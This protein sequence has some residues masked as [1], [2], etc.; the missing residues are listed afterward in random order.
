[1]R[2]VCGFQELWGSYFFNNLR[3]R[4]VYSLLADRNCVGW[5]WGRKLCELCVSNTIRNV[6][7]LWF[8][9]C[10]RRSR[11]FPASCRRSKVQLSMWVTCV[12]PSCRLPVSLKSKQDNIHKTGTHIHTEASRP[13]RPKPQALLLVSIVMSISLLSSGLK[14]WPYFVMWLVYWAWSALV[15][16]STIQ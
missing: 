8:A 16:P 2:S 5:T 14:G 4:S 7:P 11:S 9:C 13:L 10:Q 12:I 1:M 15:A 3:N 6:T